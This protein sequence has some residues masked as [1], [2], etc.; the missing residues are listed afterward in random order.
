MQDNLDTD[1]RTSLAKGLDLWLVVAETSRDGY[2]AS[3]AARRAK[4]HVATAHRLMTTLVETGFL[5]L[6]PYTKRYSIGIVPHSAMMKGGSRITSDA[7]KNKL[8]P[9]LQKLHIAHGGIVSL[10]IP[11]AHEGLCVDVIADQ[12]DIQVTTLKVGSHRPLGVGGGSLALIAGLTELER[13]RIIKNHENIYPKYGALTADFVR[14]EVQRYLRDGYVAN[15]AVIPDI[16][17]IAV[18]VFDGTTLVAAVSITNVVS[19]LDEARTKAAVSAIYRL[20]LDAG[21]FTQSSFGGR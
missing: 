16:V 12:S 19:R 9:Y 17:G 13:D 4:I 5:S 7:V 15:S 20:I 8:H 14:A 1:A 10:T 11:A 3:E 18:P 2:T 6:D 21:Y